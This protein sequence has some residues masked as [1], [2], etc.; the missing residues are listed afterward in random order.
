MI[1]AKN[2]FRLL[3]GKI[4]FEFAKESKDFLAGFLEKLAFKFLKID[5]ILTFI[6]KI[7]E[8]T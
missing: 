1:P 2:I 6:L 7:L 3:G 8:T 5:H 4:L